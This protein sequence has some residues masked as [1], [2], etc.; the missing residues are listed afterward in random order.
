MDGMISG[1]KGC[2]GN[3]ADEERQFRPPYGRFKNMGRSVQLQPDEERTEYA[4]LSDDMKKRA[5]QWLSGGK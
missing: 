3:G 2:P 1:N 5:Q 4:D